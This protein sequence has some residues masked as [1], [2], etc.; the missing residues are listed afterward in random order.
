[1]K[2]A[3]SFESTSSLVLV[4]AGTGLIAATY[5]L[6][7]LAFGLFLP[8]VRRE[9]GLALDTAGVISGGASVVYC[10]GAIAGFILA[11]R[12]ARIIATAAT[13]AGA[14][15]ALGMAVAPN[16]TLFAVFAIGSS[17]GAGLASPALVTLVGRNLPERSVPR[18][19]TVVNAGTGP[20]LALAG[21]LALLLLPDWRAAWFLSAVFTVIVGVLVLLADRG[22]APDASP[23][24]ALPPLSW[25]VDHTR[26][27][28]AALLMGFGSAAVWT[29]ARTVLVD[30]GSGETLSI[31]AWVAL[32]LGGSTVILSSRFTD[33]AEPRHLWAV[34]AG[35]IAITSAIVGVGSERPAV[36]LGAA[37]IFGWAYTAGSGALIG[38]TMRIDSE[39]AAAGTAL[40][41]VVLILG[42]AIGAVAA[43]LLVVVAGYPLAFLAAAAVGAGAA[44]MG[45]TRTR[46]GSD[47]G[48]AAAGSLR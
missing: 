14:A 35:L 48:P 31:T 39:R 45:V 25:Y 23:A 20:G 22:P 15:G 4:T 36:I 47:P 10:V 16:V 21:L 34:T 24:R 26:V 28:V 9:L 41:F 6:I 43:G 12:H 27:I 11:S 5:G 37:V 3:F 2:R 29:Y 33:R 19:Q 40:L 13:I 1:M 7:R 32:G 17:A 18:F 42:Q 8:D 30:A 44:G 46:H 38:W